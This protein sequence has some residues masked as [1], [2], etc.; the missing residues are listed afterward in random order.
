MEIILRT[1]KRYQSSVIEEINSKK[2]IYSNIKQIER[3]KDKSSY[4]VI[5]HHNKLRISNT[6][7]NKL[8][9][10]YEKLKHVTRVFIVQTTPHMLTNNYK[11]R[12]CRF[13]FDID[14]TLTPGQPGILSKESRPVL[15]ELRLQHHWIHFATSRSDGDVQDLIVQCETEPQGIAENGGLLVL[16]KTNVYELGNRE[17]PDKAYGCLKKKFKQRVILDTKQGS[18]LTERIIKNTLSRKDIDSCVKKY[19]VQVLASKNSYHIVK[20]YIHKGTALR[21]LINMRRWDNDFIVAVGD[22]DLDV[23]MFKEA[24][25]SFAVS[26]ASDL[27]KRHASVVLDNS[28]VKGVQEMFNTWFN[29]PA[30]SE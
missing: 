28:Y 26:N 20:K 9:K 1:S 5:I 14:S 10:S 2:Y 29:T 18:R 4:Y 17:E 27:A 6:Y 21:K 23:P 24:D 7:E 19:A 16:S 3:S 22:N 13:I 11:D 25:I 12:D 30:K 8:K 15:S